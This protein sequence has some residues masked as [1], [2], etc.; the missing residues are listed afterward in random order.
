MP[1]G[2]FKPPLPGDTKVRMKA[3]LASYSKTELLLS[4]V[5]KMFAGPA[6]VNPFD[7]EATSDP[8]VTLTVR[9]P[10]VALGSIVNDATAVV[11]L[12]TMTG[13]E[14][15]SAAPPTEMPGPKL[16][17]VLPWKKLLKVPVMVTVKLCPGCPELGFRLAIEAGGFTINVAVFALENLTP[18]AV[19][20]MTETR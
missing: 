2:T 6:M 10:T 19:L 4:S 15:P 7:S 14:L 17:C 16:A 18:D 9:G 20:P 1:I 8:V 3:P 11:E 5:T 12:F 13:P